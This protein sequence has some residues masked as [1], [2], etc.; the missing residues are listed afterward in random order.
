MSILSGEVTLYS[1]PRATY[2]DV[3]DWA[4]CLIITNG[5]RDH[6]VG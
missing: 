4:D 5:P 2:L 3:R 1:E 6:R